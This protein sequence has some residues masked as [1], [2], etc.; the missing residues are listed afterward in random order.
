MTLARA[1]AAQ[2]VAEYIDWARTDSVLTATAVGR[3]LG[4]DCPQR[5]GWARLRRLLTRALLEVRAA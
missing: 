1:R 5:I 3:G 2:D 4:F